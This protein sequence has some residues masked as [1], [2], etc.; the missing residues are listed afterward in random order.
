MNKLVRAFICLPIF[1]SYA[2]E[3]DGPVKSKDFPRLT[4][5]K[6]SHRL[7]EDTLPDRAPVS[8]PISENHNRAKPVS[9]DKIIAME[10]KGGLNT[11]V[12]NTSPRRNIDVVIINEKK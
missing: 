12:R 2:M 1:S 5:F 4:A 7:P 9:V 10:N 8:I 11:L 3:Q 6:R